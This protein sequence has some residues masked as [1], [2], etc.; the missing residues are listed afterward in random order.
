MEG[1]LIGINSAIFS[2]SG[3]SVGIG[4]AIPVNM[5]KSVVATAKAGGKEVR[6]PWLG[7]SLQSL[8]RDLADSLGLD[9]PNGALV[10]EVDPRGPAAEGGLK[11]GD[12]I[13]AVD[14]KDV[15][16]SGSIGYR[17]GAKPLGGVASLSIRRDGKPAVVPLKLTAAP[18][19]PP[20]D[21]VKI[22][23]ASPFAGAS[24]V[25]ISPAV[26][27]E[28]SIGHAQEGVAVIGVEENT[29]AA[30]VGFQKGDVVL[31]LNGRKN[32][33]HARPRADCGP[34]S[35]S[36]EAHDQSRRPGD[37]QR[38]RRLIPQRGN[39][40]PALL[41]TAERGPW[42]IGGASQTMGSS[43]TRGRRWRFP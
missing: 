5:V 32:P 4:F 41:F 10:A 40:L 19:R 26:A 8:S 18:E 36:L 23:G 16:D 42:P 22:T 12:V 24:V 27:E 13:T 37:H 30:M 17:L 20:R 29:A 21:P 2:Q 7:A 6:R 31:T 3:G 1:R 11:R 14:G 35:L 15:Y 28:F 33:D 9:R 38:D 43:N 34:A 25:N 39:H